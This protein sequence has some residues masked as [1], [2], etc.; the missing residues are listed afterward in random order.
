LDIHR[1]FLVEGEFDDQT[2]LG[3]VALIRTSPP[4]PPLPNGL[5]SAVRV[6]G[7]LQ[8]SSVRRIDSRIEVRLNR[9]DYDGESVT[10]ENQNGEFVIVEHG[11]WIV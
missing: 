9:G 8:I 1:P 11:V 10:L 6:N 7:S 5:P 4:A 2:L 3:V